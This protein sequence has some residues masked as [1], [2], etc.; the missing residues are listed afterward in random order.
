MIRRHPEKPN[1]HGHGRFQCQSRKRQQVWPE[2]V[3]R[4]GLGEA[5]DRSMQLLQFCAINDLSISN[6]YYRHPKKRHVT[7]ISPNDKN[8]NQIDY[9]LIQNKSRHMV[10][11]AG[12]T[13][14]PK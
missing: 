12:H 4:Y 10:K 8:K 14:Q 7:W 6:I 3:G 13:I 11:I 2:A 5:K 9:I 1:L